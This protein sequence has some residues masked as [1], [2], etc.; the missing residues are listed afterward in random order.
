MSK[1]H[2]YIEKQFKDRHDTLLSRREQILKRKVICLSELNQKYLN[3]DVEI[4]NDLKKITKQM[5][6]R[7][8]DRKKSLATKKTLF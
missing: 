2:E 5:I 1:N 7:L 8:K 3:C 4:A 6:N